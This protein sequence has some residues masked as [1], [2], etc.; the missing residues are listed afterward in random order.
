MRYQMLSDMR[1]SSEKHKVIRL[2]QPWKKQHMSWTEHRLPAM[3]CRA[4]V[5]EPDQLW[6]IFMTN[7]R[8][9]QLQEDV[10]LID[11]MMFSIQNKL[12][13]DNLA[14][15]TWWKDNYWQPVIQPGRQQDRQTD[16]RTDGQTDGRTDD[17]QAG[18]PVNT[19][20]PGSCKAGLLAWTVLQL[21]VWQTPANHANF[22]ASMLHR[23]LRNKY[24]HEII[25]S[26][27]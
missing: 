7:S 12:S 22:H 2:T 15:K 9:T 20:F 1:L 18:R 21:A 13:N 10:A 3:W 26:E 8:Q 11:L 17:R 19:P 27:H 5:S 4:K 24:S 25:L 14:V 16:R 6:I 23:Q